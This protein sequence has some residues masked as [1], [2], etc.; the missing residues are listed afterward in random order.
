MHGAEL[1]LELGGV[2][3]GLGILG[4]VAGRLGLSPIPLYLLAGLAFGKGGL[5]P[6]VTATE[7]IQTGA[8]LG[9]IL[10]LLLLGIEYSAEE[11]TASLRRSAG[12]GLV[13]L[14][15]NFTPGLAAGL[16]LG[17]PPLAAVVLAVTL[18]WGRTISRL[19]FTPNDEVL[20]LVVLGL[21]L[22]VAGLAQRLQV[23]A[24]VGAF[25][26]GIAVSGPAAASAG[27]L[28]APLRDLFAAVFFVFFGLQTDPAQIPG[29][30][31]PAL[32]LAVVT[33]LTKLATGWW[34]G[35][36][37]G[38][39]PAGRVRAGTVLVAR[40]EFSIVIAGLAVA[41]GVQARL[42]PLATAY[43]LTL[44]V[45]GPLLTRA[46]DPL[47][48]TLARPARPPLEHRTSPPTTAGHPDADPSGKATTSR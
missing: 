13:D 41:A 31:L 10:L 12:A 34:A 39:G 22:L 27:P 43:V 14:A 37:A 1:L 15:L 33:V 18:R 20:L 24:A 36:R 4:R 3:L 11:L 35:R 30:A 46:A 44:A 16:L 40:G 29:V 38:I 6:L 8:E 9:V 7:F 28:L 17:W 47:A 25:L 48:A 42:G 21:A 26:V 5:L 23:S 45:L 19:V 32:A 2:I